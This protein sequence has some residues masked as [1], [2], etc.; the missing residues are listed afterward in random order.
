[1]ADYVLPAAS[2][3]EFDDLI[4]SYFQLTLSAQA[5]AMEPMGNALP[6]LEIFRRLARAMNYSDPE[7]HEGAAAI[8]GTLMERSG[9]RMT[10]AALA[11][12]GSIWVPQQP[13]VPFAG[14]VFEPTSGRMG[15]APARRAAA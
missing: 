7:L 9:L 2:F 8:L 13:A 1:M 6:N 4:A 10:F 12:R 3:L 5:K 15:R 14:R 11:E